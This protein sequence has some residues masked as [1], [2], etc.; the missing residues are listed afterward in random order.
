MQS[1]APDDGREWRTVS[2]MI[3]GEPVISLLGL[4]ILTG[5]DEKD[6]SASDLIPSAALQD[7]RRRASETAA[8]TG[9]RDFE[10]ALQFLAAQMG[11][12]VINPTASEI[13][14]A[15]KVTA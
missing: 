2:K 12:D 5:W 10:D 3:D 9:S 8:S 6:L 7:G 14:A 4:A 13:L 11:Y 1:N 15:K